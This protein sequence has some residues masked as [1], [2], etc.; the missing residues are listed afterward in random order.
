MRGGSGVRGEKWKRDEI[1]KRFDE[2]PLMKRCVVFD[3]RLA[4]WLERT[5]E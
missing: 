1:D 3:G 4:N 5:S 2:V